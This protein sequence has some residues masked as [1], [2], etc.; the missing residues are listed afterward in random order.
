MNCIKYQQSKVIICDIVCN[1]L[2]SRVFVTVLLKREEFYFD[3]RQKKIVQIRRVAEQDFRLFFVCDF[4][5]G[6][7]T[8][9]NSRISRY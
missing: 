3:Q 8:G 5:L 4:D 9:L 6:I 2:E 7:F 1:V